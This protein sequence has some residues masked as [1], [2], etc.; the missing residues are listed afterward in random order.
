[1]NGGTGRIEPATD[2][3]IEHVA[4]F[5]FELGHE[6]RDGHDPGLAVLAQLQHARLIARDEDISV[7]RLGNSKKN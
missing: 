2:T 4:L 6:V 5:Q 3:P 7:C 1:V